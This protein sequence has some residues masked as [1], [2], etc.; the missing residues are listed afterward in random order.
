[1]KDDRSQ[2]KKLKAIKMKDDRSQNKKLKAIKKAGREIKK[3][4]KEHNLEF[5]F[6]KHGASLT[7]KGRDFE[8]TM[9]SIYPDGS[10]NTEEA[11]TWK[12]HLKDKWNYKEEYVATFEGSDPSLVEDLDLKIEQARRDAQ[13]AKET[14]EN[15]QEER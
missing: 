7:T 8:S 1:M 13:R 14:Y 2:N 15:Y 12:Q 9:V 10:I 5:K 3:I 6:H 11:K 4:L